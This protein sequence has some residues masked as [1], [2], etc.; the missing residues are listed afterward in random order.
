MLSCHHPGVRAPPRTGPECSGNIYV[1]TERNTLSPSLSIERTPQSTLEPQLG[2]EN[3]AGTWPRVYPPN[4]SPH[5]CL[6]SAC[7]PSTWGQGGPFSPTDPQGLILCSVLECVLAESHLFSRLI[8]LS[9]GGLPP[10]PPR[11]LTIT[12]NYHKDPLQRAGLPPPPP[13][14]RPCPLGQA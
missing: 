8:Q 7:V 2:Q 9:P 12:I 3:T 13:P 6:C 4:C 1:H 10:C 11:P 5:H 14:P